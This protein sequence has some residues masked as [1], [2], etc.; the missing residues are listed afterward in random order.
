MYSPD[1][2][3]QYRSV[4][5]NF[6]AESYVPKNAHEGKN[7]ACTA[8][9]Y[10][11][12]QYFVYVLLYK[13]WRFTV[14]N[15]IQITFHWKDISEFC[16]R[17]YIFIILPNTVANVRSKISC[18]MHFIYFMANKLVENIIWSQVLWENER[19]E[20]NYVFN[21]YGVVGNIRPQIIMSRYTRGCW[22][23]SRSESTWFL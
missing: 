13:C 14:C 22:P 16:S 3:T 7:E 10:V 20:K 6:G 1:H 18:H 17:G 5:R 23:H 12:Q 19:D 15:N 9:R 2:A 8:I 4:A 11:G 21:F